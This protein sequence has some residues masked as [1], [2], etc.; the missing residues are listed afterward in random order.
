M[1]RDVVPIAA[2]RYGFNYESVPSMEEVY[3]SEGFWRMRKDLAHGKLAD[4][5]RDCHA[6]ENYSWKKASKS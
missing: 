3:N 2:E 6:C 4:F 1:D 5:C